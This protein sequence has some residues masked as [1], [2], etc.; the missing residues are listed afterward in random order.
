MIKIVF[1]KLIKEY[2]QAHYNQTLIFANDSEEGYILEH[3][4]Y[5]SLDTGEKVFKEK[6]NIKY[7]YEIDQLY[8]CT[9][10]YIDSENY[11]FETGNDIKEIN[12]QIFIDS[13]FETG[14]AKVF[15][16]NIMQY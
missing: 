10:L 13:L 1:E 5:T 2:K 11:F 9:K 12:E 16:I 15:L 6:Y 7:S 8:Q 3:L 14:Q 4:I